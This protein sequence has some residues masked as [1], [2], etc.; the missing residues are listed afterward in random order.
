MQQLRFTK[1]RPPA[2]ADI[3]SRAVPFIILDKWLDLD[4]QGNGTQT[5]R[6]EGQ[7]LTFGSTMFTWE[8]MDAARDS[9]WWASSLRTWTEIRRWFSSLLSC[10]DFFMPVYHVNDQEIHR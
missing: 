7:T 4:T 6:Q 9:M 1:E 10:A 8:V 2:P 5:I 3:Q